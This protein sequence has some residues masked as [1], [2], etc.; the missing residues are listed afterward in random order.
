M[1]WR[2]AVRMG[3]A[4]VVAL[5]AS[6]QTL[7]QTP[8]QSSDDAL[9]AMEQMAGVIFSGQ[10]TAVRR[11][12]GNDGGAGVVEIEFAVDDAVRG[13]SGGSYTLR[14]WAGL[15]PGDDEPF[16][17]GQRFLMLLYAPSAAGLSSPVGGMD[18]AIPIRGGGA[19]ATSGSGLAT[20][21]SVGSGA[22]GLV[23]DMR[24]VQTQVVRPLAY[25]AD[26]V[27]RPVGA[28]GGMRANLTQARTEN[29]AETL[30]ESGPAETG[31]VAEATQPTAQP[32]EAYAAVLGKLRGWARSDHGS[33]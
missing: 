18:G 3:C 10:V 11:E 7:G 28:L 27:A 14:E 19:G 17:V 26:S 25:R 16:R 2:D 23:M 8:A 22:T 21:A 29:L 20:A 5:I 1:A 4:I 12:V 6:G 15:W 30:L 32:S 31:A 33:R 9:R 13:V 24:W